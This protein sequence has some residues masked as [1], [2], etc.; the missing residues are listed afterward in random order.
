MA[1]PPPKDGSTVPPR[2]GEP[3]GSRKLLLERYMPYRLSVLGTL[4]TQGVAKRYSARFGIDIPEWR[5]IAALGEW[6]SMT[7]K[8]IGSQSHMH[9]TKV[10]RAVAGLL[11]RG[12]IEKRPNERDLREAFLRLT[13]PGRRIYS[14]IVPLARAYG[15]SL[16]QGF[17]MAELAALDQV[18]DRLTRRA[19]DLLEAGED[20]T[21][22]SQGS[23]KRDRPRKT[24]ADGIVPS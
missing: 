21:A 12:L 6:G 19:R 3:A 7:A 11:S 16:T 14:E 4:V 15:E 13:R 24:G 9:K 17:T 23:P 1:A 20:E 22:A 2:P 10:S 5:V 8:E 18:V